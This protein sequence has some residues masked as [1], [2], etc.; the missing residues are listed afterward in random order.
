MTATAP[1]DRKKAHGQGLRAESLAV[2]LLRLKGYRILARRYQIREGEIDIVARRGDTVV[3]VEVEGQAN[4]R[5]GAD[6]DRP[7]QAAAHLAGSKK[8]ACFKS[9][10]RAFDMAG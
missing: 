3:F 1:R 9:L 5:R 6:H 10:G 7:G 2:G 4:S 8:L